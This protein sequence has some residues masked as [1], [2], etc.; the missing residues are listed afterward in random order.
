MVRIAISLVAYQALASTMPEGTARSP[1][2]LEVG[3]GVG[4][5]IDHATLAALK[6]E[7]GAGEGWSEVILSLCSPPR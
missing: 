6:R 5:W 7:R 1:E 3:E 4:L 2:P